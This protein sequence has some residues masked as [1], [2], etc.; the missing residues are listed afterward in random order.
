MTSPI[1]LTGARAIFSIATLSRGR[2]PL[3]VCLSIF[4]LGFAALEI[5]AQEEPTRPVVTGAIVLEVDNDN[6]AILGS[7]LIVVVEFNEGVRVTAAPRVALTIGAT[8]RHALYRDSF[9]FRIDETPCASGT[10]S[11]VF[12]YVIQASDS[13][14][15]G[16]S[17]PP[18]ALDLNGGAIRDADN[19]PANLDLGSHAITNNPDVRVDG[20][21]SKDPGRVVAVDIA[22][23]PENGDTYGVGEI[24]RVVFDFD[25][26]LIVTGMPQAEL[27]IGDATRYASYDGPVGEPTEGVGL[28]SLD[29]VYTVQAGDHDTDGISIPADAID[30]NGGA[31]VNGTAGNATPITADLSHAA[32]S[33]Q[34]DHKVDATAPLPAP[35]LPLL[36]QM[37]LAML[38]AG[39]GAYYRARRQWA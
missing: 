33:A 1:S 12:R 29:F 8:T 32:V 4:L 17:I 3:A 35:A 24:I 23:I 13:D 7:V 30:V 26:E 28:G 6:P 19:N 31:V 37:L 22:S 5:R 14:M 38:L 36:A 39:A 20:S 21:R 15:D 27:T 9:P 34:A 25:R 18:D 10:C 11:L 2:A 16:V